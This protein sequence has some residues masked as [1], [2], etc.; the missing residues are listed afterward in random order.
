[1][2]NPDVVLA[3]E[4]TGDLDPETGQAVIDV[5]WKQT[6][7]RGRSFLIVTHDYSIARRANRVLRIAQGRLHPEKLD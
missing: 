5:I 3:D 1:M 4:P 7:G 2:N 6:V